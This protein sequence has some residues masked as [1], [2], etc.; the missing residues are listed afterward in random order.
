MTD[1][2]EL[3]YNVYLQAVARYEEAHNQLEAI[4]ESIEDELEALVTDDNA[5]FHVKQLGRLWVA[6][7]GA[8]FRCMRRAELAA[9]SELHYK[10][11]ITS[12]LADEV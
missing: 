9:A 1:I 6:R 11:C 12:I 10:V 5:L 3:A 4:E 7:Q 2:R 8:R